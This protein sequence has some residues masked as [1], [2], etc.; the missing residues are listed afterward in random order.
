M[1]GLEITLDKASK[2]K[3]YHQLYLAFVNA[4]EKNELPEGTKIPS[5]RT[6]SEEYNISRNTVTKAYS[7]LQANGYVYSLS[8]SGFFTKSPSEESP[9][10][11]D[12]PPVLAEKDS[13]IPT[14][15]SIIKERMKENDTEEIPALLETASDSRQ[16]KKPELFI[17]KD[18]FSFGTN[19]EETEIEKPPFQKDEKADE[20]S[21][22]ES[23]NEKTEAESSPEEAFVASAA[24]AIK[25]YKK[26]LAETDNADP[27]GEEFL[28][29]AIASFLYQFHH[30]DAD[31]S[32]I[33]ISSNKENL[34][35]KL[36]MLDE[37]KKTAGLHGLLQLAEK[38]IGHTQKEKEPSIS[39]VSLNGSSLGTVFQTAGFS[40]NSVAVNS[41]KPLSA[42]LEETRCSAA[43][44]YSNDFGF[45][46]EQRV[47]ELLD[48]LKKEEYRYVIEY[49]TSTQPGE[50]QSIYRMKK[51]RCVYL[52]N[53]S[54]LISKSVSVA[55]AV[56][57]KD[58]IASYKKRYACLES[59]LSLLSQ[60][61][62]TD[63]LKKGKFTKYLSGIEQI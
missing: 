7:E 59:P 25:E 9:E 34:L 1:K 14:V 30:I 50:I 5:I 54:H 37:F 55:I 3:L 38:S 2:V 44:I 48:W 42:A 60:I 57:P 62:L 43:F 31:A 63:Y 12:I 52:S 53:F 36:L 49:D 39:I 35:F 41:Q 22:K 51:D 45:G 46:Q 33:I 15:D 18:P 13:I 47:Q 24:T 4:I 11:P 26:L 10:K 27:M 56:L 17:M 16:H 19:G 20:F 61:A 6:L 28:R 40:V 8:K 23:A 32:Q 58:L 29:I 21:G